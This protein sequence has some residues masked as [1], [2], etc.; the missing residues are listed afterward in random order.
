MDDE[1]LTLGSKPERCDDGGRCH[2]INELEICLQANCE[3]KLHCKCS[4]DLQCFDDLQC[5]LYGADESVCIPYE[6]TLINAAG[7]LSASIALAL[8]SLIATM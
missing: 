7:L 8:L 3:G 2:A 5:A 1:P 6:A 4:A